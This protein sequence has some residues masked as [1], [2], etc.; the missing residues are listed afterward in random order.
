MSNRAETFIRLGRPHEAADDC[1][2]ARSLLDQH[3]E[4]IQVEQLQSM[5]SKLA[6]RESKAAYAAG[7]TAQED[8][9]MAERVAAVAE[10]RAFLT[11][12][13]EEATETVV[14]QAKS[15]REAGSM[16]EAVVLLVVKLVAMPWPPSMAAMQLEVRM[17][18]MLAWESMVKAP[19]VTVRMALVDSRPHP[20][21]AVP[22]FFAVGGR[23]SGSTCKS[24][25]KSMQLS[26]ICGTA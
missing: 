21:R 17:G 18:A 24:S 8:A 2:D 19:A 13:S 11:T 3:S 16:V 23:R 14:A 15:I 22:A 7:F 12:A 26:M 20:T 9:L 4:V 10:T 6:L 1:A 25:L 5:V